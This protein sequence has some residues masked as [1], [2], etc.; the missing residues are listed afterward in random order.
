MLEKQF[1]AIT[2]QDILDRANV[3]RSTFYEHFTD[4]EDL[5]M[6]G[7]AQVIH[8]LEEPMS[9]TGRAPGVVLP[10]LEFF[11]HIQQMRRLIRA[12]VWGRSVETLMREFQALLSKVVEQNL[13]SFSSGESVSPTTLSVVG[14]F[15]ASTFLMLVQWWFENDLR[16]SPEEMDELFQQLVMPGVQA[17]LDHRT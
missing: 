17:A 6:G 10:S 15:V 1:A 2:V 4:K 5:L 3:G 7:I 12:F 9:A 8:Q 16:Q 11:R 13:Q 14:R